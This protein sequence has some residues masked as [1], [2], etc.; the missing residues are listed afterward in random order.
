ML[1]KETVKTMRNTQTQLFYIVY[2]IFAS[3][4]IRLTLNI[5]SFVRQCKTFTSLGENWHNRATTSGGE[6]SITEDGRVRPK[7]DIIQ[8]KKRMSN[9]DGQKNKYSQLFCVMQNL[10]VGFPC[11]KHWAL[12]LQV[13]RHEDKW[14]GGTGPHISERVNRWR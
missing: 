9:I 5:C 3:C 7:H 12:K 8:Y 1:I 6:Y 2:C 14:G 13:P 10:K 4:Y 11:I